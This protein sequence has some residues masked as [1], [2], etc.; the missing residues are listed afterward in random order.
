[1]EEKLRAQAETLQEQAS[2]LDVPTMRLSFGIWRR[3][4][5]LE[6][7]RRIALWL[8]QGRAVGQ[9]SHSLLQTQYPQSMT[10][11]E[12]AVRRDGRW[13]GEL[14]HVKRDGS[15]VIVASRKSCNKTRRKRPRH[16]GNQQ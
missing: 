15:R 12:A 8:E 13:E 9:I 10:E 7:W 5:L 2:L 4:S 16:T 11:I 14:S 6:P 1:V 3:N